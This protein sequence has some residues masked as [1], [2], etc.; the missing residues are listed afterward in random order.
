[1]NAESSYGMVMLLLVGGMIAE[2]Q[3]FSHALLLFYGIFNTDMRNF[4]VCAMAIKLAKKDVDSDLGKAKIQDLVKPVDVE[5][6]C[7]QAAK[8]LLSRKRFQAAVCE[9]VSPLTVM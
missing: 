9:H 4:S 7:R 5:W 2:G 3:K 6:M 8:R 1:M